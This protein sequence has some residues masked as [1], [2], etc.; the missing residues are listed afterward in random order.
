MICAGCVSAL[1]EPPPI[2]GSAGDRLSETDAAMDADSRRAEELWAVRNLQA[3]REAATLWAEAAAARR[4]PVPA[5]LDLARARVWLAGHEP[6]A[7]ARREA[8][9]GAVHAGQWCRQL[10]PG[11]PACAYWL[12]AALGVQARER[13]ATALDALP[14]IVGL[15]REARRGDPSLDRA[16]PD[17]ALALLYVRAPGWPS[18]PG[19]PDLGLEHAGLAVDREPGYP[20]NRLCLA[21]A[22]L[23][24]DDLEGSR[25]NYTV[26]L[27][28]SLE[29]AERGEPD[30][31]EWLEE[32]RKGLERLED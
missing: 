21:E 32:A 20:P 14:R 11:S 2:P 23:A 13:R 15:F 3:V 16:G 17:R 8:A 27:S 24:V 5:I 9:T 6:E 12:G 28:L 22:M 26:A 18:G 1:K 7:A 31:R 30:A 10:R 25:E 29:W 19:D 4:D